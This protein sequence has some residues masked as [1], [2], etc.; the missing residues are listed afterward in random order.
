MR[1]CSI[2]W[3]HATEGIGS[4]KTEASYNDSFVVHKSNP[5]SAVDS[6]RGLRG[7]KISVLTL[8]NFFFL[9]ERRVMKI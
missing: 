5:W 6:N 1:E 2:W 9:Q 7:E 3:N 4:T 8:L